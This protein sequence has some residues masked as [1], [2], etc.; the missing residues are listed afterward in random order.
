M[1][2]A[3]AAAAAVVLLTALNLYWIQQNLALHQQINQLITERAAEKQAENGILVLLA[4]DERL[5]IDLPAAQE[6]SQANAEVLWDPAVSV[7]MLYAKAF[8][9]L[10]PDKVYQLWLT[11]NGQRQSGGLFTVDP[12]GTGVLLF[13][14][15]QPL[16]NLESMGVTPEPAGG[17]PGPTAPPVVRRRFDS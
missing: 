10:P 2:W 7:A 13:P 6:N 16:D 9:A 8:P 12:N 5:A 15:S 11:S 4:S 14:I 1:V 3:G 17:S